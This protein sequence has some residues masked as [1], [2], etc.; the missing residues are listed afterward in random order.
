MSKIQPQRTRKIWQPLNEKSQILTTIAVLAVAPFQI[1][2]WCSV[3]S[4][5]LQPLPV[6]QSPA[7]QSK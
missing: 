2:S 3:Q 7:N 5:P 6:Q 4:P 1:Y